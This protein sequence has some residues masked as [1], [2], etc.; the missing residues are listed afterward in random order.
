[1]NAGN[2]RQATAINTKPE[3]MGSR[4]HRHGIYDIDLTLIIIGDLTKQ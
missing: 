1:M 4:S 3:L 2:R